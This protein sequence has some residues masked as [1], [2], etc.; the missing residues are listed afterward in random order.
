MRRLML[1]ILAAD[2][3]DWLRVFG[4]LVFGGRFALLVSL[5]LSILPKCRHA[6][7]AAIEIY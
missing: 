6:A 1:L 5:R 2:S 3:D 7:Y 4:G